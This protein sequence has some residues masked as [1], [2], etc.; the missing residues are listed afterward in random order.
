LATG[1]PC[2]WRDPS[3]RDPQNNRSA[4]AS[5]PFPPAAPRPA[6]HALAVQLRP[7]RYLCVLC[8]FTASNA[9]RAPE[10][11]SAPPIASN[12]SRRPGVSPPPPHGFEC[13][14]LSAHGSPCVGRPATTTP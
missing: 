2:R 11:S 14:R 1:A 10:P 13:L 7:L 3:R 4:A 5:Q 9:S 8:V 6:A 12:A